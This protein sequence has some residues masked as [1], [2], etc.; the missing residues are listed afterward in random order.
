MAT[1]FLDESRFSLKIGGMEIASNTSAGTIDGQLV[2][3]DWVIVNESDELIF[4]L[5][6]VE[7]MRLNTSGIVGAS[8]TAL[9]FQT[10]TYTVTNSDT[11]FSGADDFGTT[12][13]YTDGRVGAYLN[14]IRLVANTDFTATGG[15]SVTFQEAT[16]N[17]DIV[18]VETF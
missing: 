9:N 18:T 13:S 5:N 17:G 2:F 16:S 14:G 12:L 3:G 7:K 6:N 1:N 15:S 10:Y 11:V 4:K 8:S